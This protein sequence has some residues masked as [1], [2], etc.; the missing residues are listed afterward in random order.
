MI[1]IYEYGLRLAA[2]AEHLVDRDRHQRTSFWWSRRS[3]APLGRGRHSEAPS[4]RVTLPRALR[5][6]GTAWPAVAGVA[7]LLGWEALT[8]AT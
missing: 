1:R 8:E 4:R 6:P 5:R 2:E 7:A 3:V